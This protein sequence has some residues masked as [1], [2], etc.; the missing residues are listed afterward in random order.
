VQEDLILNPSGRKS[1]A[2]DAPRMKS[3]DL[4]LPFKRTSVSYISKLSSPLMSKSK[5]NRVSQV[6]VDKLL[7]AVHDKR[8]NQA[9]ALLN[10]IPPGVLKKRFPYEANMIFL[11]AMMNRM[12]KMACMILDRGFPHNVNQPIFTMRSS[13]KYPTHIPFRINASLFP[14]YFIVAVAM[15]FETLIRFMIKAS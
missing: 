3:K 6:L 12:E 8:E 14:S 10:E 9:Q 1:T 2:K 15:N 5:I 13:K 11:T 4:D 7:L